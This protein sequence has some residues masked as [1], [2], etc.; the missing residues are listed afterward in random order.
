M[1]QPC[2]F[3]HALHS[4][5]TLI[6]YS[7]AHV[8]RGPVPTDTRSRTLCGHPTLVKANTLVNLAALTLDSLSSSCTR[9]YRL[10]L[11]LP[12]TTLLILPWSCQLGIGFLSFVVTLST[13]VI[14]S[15]LFY[16][17]LSSHDAQ[18]ALAIFCRACRHIECM[19]PHSRRR[20]Y[21]RPNGKY[22]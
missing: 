6:R 10:L 19:N 16:W 18:S 21:L 3:S 14:L 9:Q 12:H 17:T 22:S 4:L 1:R 15:C 7:G 11:L 13:I 20:L 5:L 8:F 2:A